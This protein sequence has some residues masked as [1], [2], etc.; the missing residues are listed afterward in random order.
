[1]M[2]MLYHPIIMETSSMIFSHLT[3]ARLT[4]GLLPNDQLYGQDIFLWIWEAFI[5]IYPH[6]LFSVYSH[7]ILGT[8]MFRFH[9]HGKSSSNTC[10][11]K[12]F[13]ISFSGPVIPYNTRKT[14]HIHIKMPSYLQISIVLSIKSVVILRHIM[15]QEEEGYFLANA[16]VEHRM[17]ESALFFSY[18]HP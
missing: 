13:T 7:D 15:Q 4:L 3:S 16:V 11:S 12:K 14:F 2:I 6:F 18:A 1:M 10:K 9:G 8:I 17:A 5:C